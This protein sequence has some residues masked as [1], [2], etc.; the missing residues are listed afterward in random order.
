MEANVM[1]AAFSIVRLFVGLRTET[2]AVWR[3]VCS[4]VDI[5]MKKFYH[6]A[7]SP[8]V[9]WRDPFVVRLV[10]ERERE[11]ERRHAG[12]LIQERLTYQ[13]HV[14]LAKPHFTVPLMTSP[15]GNS[16]V[17]EIRR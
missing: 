10:I 11:R 6:T 3:P 5:L 9:T 13:Q 12:N 7:A 8:S 16:K 17:P 2:L 4:P 14:G 1:C 15:H